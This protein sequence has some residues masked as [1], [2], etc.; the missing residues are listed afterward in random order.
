MTSAVGQNASGAIVNGHSVHSF[1]KLFPWF[2]Y[3]TCIRNSTNER[4]EELRDLNRHYN[5]MF[6]D[7]LKEYKRMGCPFK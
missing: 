5:Y 3:D 6:Q 1:G 7:P 2:Y 4:Q